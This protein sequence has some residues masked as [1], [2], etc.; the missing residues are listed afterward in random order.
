VRD[1]PSHAVFDALIDAG[2]SVQ[3]FDPVAME[4]MQHMYEDHDAVSYT[5][6]NYEALQ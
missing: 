2:A 3:A 1:A 5:A 4:E 6:T